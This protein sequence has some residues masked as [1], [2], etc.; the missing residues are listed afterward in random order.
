[1]NFVNTLPSSAV[2]Q[3]SSNYLHPIVENE[4]DEE[5]KEVNEVEEVIGNSYK[6]KGCGQVVMRVH[7]QV[8]ASS[9]KS[10]RNYFMQ[11]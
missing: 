6:N 8:C 1:M 10:M 4:S 7:N 9:A 2:A 5:E 11:C 3:S